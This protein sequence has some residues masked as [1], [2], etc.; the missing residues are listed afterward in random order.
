ME[1]LISNPSYQ[2]AVSLGGDFIFIKLKSN[3][4]IM[5]DPITGEAICSLKM[6]SKLFSHSTK[7]GVRNVAKSINKAYIIFVYEDNTYSEW[8]AAQIFT[9]DNTDIPFI[10]RAVS[11]NGHWA[12]RQTKRGYSQ[13]HN[14]RT[15]EITPFG[16]D[17][18]PRIANQDKFFW[19]KILLSNDAQFIVRAKYENDA[20]DQESDVLLTD[21]T[22]NNTIPIM[23][24]YR[25]RTNDIT[26][27]I[28]SDNSNLL[29]IGF[30]DGSIG[31]YRVK[32]SQQIFRSYVHNHPV[33]SI[34]HKTI[35]D[36]LALIS[37]A[38][39]GDLNVFTKQTKQNIGFKL[40]NSL[41][42]VGFAPDNQHIIVGEFIKGYERCH[43]FEIK[44]PSKQDILSTYTNL[45]QRQNS[46]PSL[47]FRKTCEVD[48]YYC[49]LYNVGTEDEGI[50]CLQNNG[51]EL[52]LLFK[53]YDNAV[54]FIQMLKDQG[55][56]IPTPEQINEHDIIK[57]CNISGYSWE[58]V[59]AG[60]NT[61][62]Q[63]ELHFD[64]APAEPF[65]EIGFICGPGLALCKFYINKH[66]YYEKET[67]VKSSHL[68]FISAMAPLYPETFTEDAQGYIM[69]FPE[70]RRTYYK[71]RITLSPL[72]KDKNVW[73]SYCQY[74]VTY[75]NVP[76]TED[77]IFN[78]KTNT[79]FEA[80]LLRFLD[81]QE[82][83]LGNHH[84]QL[85]NTLDKLVEVYEVQDKNYETQT[86]KLRKIELQKLYKPKE[87]VLSLYKSKNH[88]HTIFGVCGARLQFLII[89]LK[90]NLFAGYLF[91]EANPNITSEPL[92][93]SCIKLRISLDKVVY[94]QY[95]SSSKIVNQIDVV[96]DLS[97]FQR[98]NE[99]FINIVESTSHLF[100]PDV[101]RGSAPSSGVT[102]EVL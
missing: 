68:Y 37:G 98:V 90:A 12:L 31:C 47:D 13:I 51:K 62:I 97:L 26:S 40:N 15:G 11:Q 42:V 27:L 78:R 16:R 3:T 59:P 71:L 17:V 57:F 96:P 77:F 43:V 2:I 83:L 95:E 76:S 9:G 67:Y 23:L 82:R 33:T 41:S 63:K 21:L 50:H 58:I 24:N 22:K 20:I 72:I 18:L 80:Q 7:G 1:S 49:L 86:T 101:N 89:L 84:E 35:E 102:Q 14:L 100:E 61:L 55:L 38:S 79:E 30:S 25:I 53:S 5:T 32:D 34:A 73:D 69:F 4:L 88:R 75:E 45:I 81:L 52:V 19:Q 64:L 36:N 10:Y 74:N 56:P 70:D 66:L 92:H 28:L 85:I 48:K 54:F 87:I 91:L 60:D 94:P 39:N 46:L 6:R 29:L 44:T 65:R 8:L 93:S 99:Y